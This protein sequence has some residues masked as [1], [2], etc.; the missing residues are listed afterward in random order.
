MTKEQ[1]LVIKEKEQNLDSL[2]LQLVLQKS[3]LEEL[4][5]SEAKLQ[6]E[7]GS[8]REHCLAEMLV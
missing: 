5:K 6:K 3:D 8:E 1:K 2:E 7:E 4:D